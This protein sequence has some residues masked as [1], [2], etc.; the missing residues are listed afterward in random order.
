MR[1]PYSRPNIF[2]RSTFWPNS[3]WLCGLVLLTV[4]VGGGSPVW[5][6]Q[7]TVTFSGRVTEQNTAQGIAG[8]AIIA[9][10]N[11]TGARVAITNAQGNYSLPFGANTNIRL[12][13]YKTGFVFNPALVGFA[14]VCGPAITGT[15][16]QDYSGVRLPFPILIFAQP[17]ILLTE[18]VRTI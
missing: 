13:A 8:V 18:D 11:W 10:G 16:S 15:L 17:P 6:Q 12:R 4:M 5:S 7:P 2:C 3:P 1:K 9:Q 14:S